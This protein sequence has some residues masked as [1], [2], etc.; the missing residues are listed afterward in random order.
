MVRFSPVTVELGQV[1]VRVVRGHKVRTDKLCRFQGEL[2]KRLCIGSAWYETVG[3]V[4]IARVVVEID[5][6]PDCIPV[7]HGSSGFH[8]FIQ[9]IEWFPI[10]LPDPDDSI[11]FRQEVCIQAGRFPR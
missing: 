7:L 10:V 2:C 11:G 3:R 5:I 1:Q 8:Y 6:E 4:V 9:G